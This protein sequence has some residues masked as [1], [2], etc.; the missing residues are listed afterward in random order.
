MVDL[1][2]L[3]VLQGADDALHPVY[4]QIGIV[5]N[6]LGQRPQDAAGGGEEAG[7]AGVALL[8]DRDG[9]NALLGHPGGQ[10][11][12][13]QHRVHQISVSL[14]L[15]LLRHA[16][17]DED[18]FRFRVRPLDCGAVRLHGGLDV[19][20]EG[21]GR[22]EVFFNQQV[23][24]M[25]AGGDQNIPL[26][27][28]K[29]A[30]VL[31]LY[32]GGAEGG[33]LNGCKTQLLQRSFHPANAD[34]LVIRDEGRRKTHI[35]GGAALDQDLDLFGFIHDLFGVLRAD[36]HALS[37]EDAVLLHDVGLIAGEADGLDRAVSDALVTVLAVRFFQ[38]QT[39]CHSI[40][41]QLLK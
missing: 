17:A 4:Y 29:Q 1:A 21:Q 36:H 12:K 23:D 40:C 24:G 11:L 32:H 5:G 2:L 3:D 7:Q 34:P 37:A 30:I 28:P 9:N 38:G 6:A 25:A 13:G 33:F 20:Q 14:G 31:P 10:L 41:L 18:G 26:L 22:G 39:A 35:D 16:G 19:C 8:L 15:V 27:L